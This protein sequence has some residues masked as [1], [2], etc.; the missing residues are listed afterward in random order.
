MQILSGDNILNRKQCNVLRGIAIMGIFL[1]NFCHWL[2]GAQ[3][4]NEY[5]FKLQNSHN[6]WDYWTRGGIDSFFPIQFFSYF[7]HYGVPLFLFLSGFGLVMKYERSN[8]VVTAGNF[9]SYNWL[10]L[11]RLMVLG[12]LLSFIT[13][14][15]CGM[16]MQ[17]WHEILGQLTMV[18]NLFPNPGGVILPGPYWFFGLMLQVYI[19]YRLLAYP[20]RMPKTCWRWLMPL[21]L[22]VVAW[23]M[24]A[25]LFP[26]QGTLNYM[27]YNA[28]VAMLPF[29][30]GVLVA[31]YGLPRLSRLS[32]VTIAVL[33]FV[34]L[35]VANLNFQSWLW[36][37]VLVIA[38]AV[39]FVK[40]LESNDNG[41]W[42]R[43]AHWIMAPLAWMG[44]MSSYIFVVHSIVRM[45][46][47]KWVMW[48]QP[49]LMLTDYLWLALYI[50]LTILLAWLYKQYL[51]LVPKPRL[52][53]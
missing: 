21:L 19:I 48:R 24:Q 20:W 43:A 12:Y 17:S 9:L 49:N 4:E 10:K 26:Y 2:H 40:A 36:S 1:H 14:W 16:R 7:G 33:S 47:F 44:V 38:G 30:A 41:S 39:S 15:L 13:Y 51:R 23:I 31:R 34:L 53:W 6:M 27:R 28:V 42:P 52:K 50:V 3:Q 22:I 46:I 32:L 18:I 25:L 5:M 29:C 45:P 37:P 35:A 8:K 11:F